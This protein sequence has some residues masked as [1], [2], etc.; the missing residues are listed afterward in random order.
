MARV[1]CETDQGRMLGGGPRLAVPC[2]RRL[3]N[4]EQSLHR[5]SEAYEPDP[6]LTPGQLRGRSEVESEPDSWSRSGSLFSAV[7]L[8]FGDSR[9]RNNLLHLR[10]P[11]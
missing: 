9:G 6:S 8:D 4:A 3:G 5:G 7:L 11:A 10:T 1:G 2:R